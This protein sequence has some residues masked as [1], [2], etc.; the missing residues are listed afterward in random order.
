[1]TLNTDHAAIVGVQIFH[2][3]WVLKAR[4][5]RLRLCPWKHGIHQLAASHSQYRQQ[6]ITDLNL[7]VSYDRYT[8]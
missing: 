8:R 5:I 4:T 1:M 3:G 2:N 7:V 6:G